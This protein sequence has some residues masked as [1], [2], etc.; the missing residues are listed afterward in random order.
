M[1][2][3]IFSHPN[4]RFSDLRL[5]HV[6][7]SSQVDYLMYSVFNPIMNMSYVN[8]YL[9]AHIQSINRFVE[10]KIRKSKAFKSK[11]RTFLPQ[12]V[13]DKGAFE[14]SLREKKYESL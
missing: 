1:K 9:K 5:F 3:Q 12:R 6:T 7:S 14:Y 2:Q 11:N 8:C 10:A 13:G 4:I